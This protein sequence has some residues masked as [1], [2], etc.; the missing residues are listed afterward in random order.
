MEIEYLQRNQYYR[1]HHR[2]DLE[3][4]YLVDQHSLSPEQFCRTTL[5]DL[6]HYS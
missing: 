5:V 4:T 2:H 6:N 1:T 3:N